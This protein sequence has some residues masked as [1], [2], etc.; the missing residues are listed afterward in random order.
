MANYPYILIDAPGTYGAK[1]RVRSRHR[2][3]QSACIARER[4]L[5]FAPGQ[6][7]R[8]S[9]VL[10]KNPGDRYRPGDEFPADSP[11]QQIALD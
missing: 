6:A 9:V 5:V 3:L 2:T 10:A 4:H 8:Y 1:G 11:P 7:P